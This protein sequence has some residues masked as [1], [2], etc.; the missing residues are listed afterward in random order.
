MKHDRAQTFEDVWQA[1]Q[2]GAGSLHIVDK[3]LTVTVLSLIPANG[4]GKK[5]QEK[6]E[7]ANRRCQSSLS[8]PPIPS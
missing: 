7:K 4:E 5:E 8:S 1:V 2:D 3:K 6:K